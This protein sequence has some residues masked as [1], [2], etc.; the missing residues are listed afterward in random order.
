MV[1]MINRNRFSNHKLSNFKVGNKVRLCWA[2]SPQNL[3]RFG[4]VVD[5]RNPNVI[6]KLETYPNI[7][8]QEG[9][10]SPNKLE[11]INLDKNIICK[12]NQNDK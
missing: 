12:K 7:I 4:I 10:F 6:V 2:F 1:K 8:L 5:I 11:I 9:Y 3:N